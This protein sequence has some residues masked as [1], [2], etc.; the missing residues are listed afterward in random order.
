MRHLGDYAASTVIY[1]K[2][3][4]FR[5]STGAA[6]TLGGTPA[7]SV[8]KDNSTTQSTTGVTLTADFDAVTGLNHFA[9]DT[10]ADGAFYTAGS[11]FD[12]VITTGTVDSVS[13]V[14]TVV[15]SFSLAKTAALRPTTAGRT[16]DVTA[17]GEAG[18]DWSNIGGATTTVNLSGTTIKTATDVETDT[19][20]IQTKI[21]T[22]AG[23]SVSADIAAV[24]ADTAAI[25]IDTAEIG[26]AGAGLTAL[27]SA[28]N[29]A[30]VA[31][32][33]DTEVGTIVTAV[34]NI[35][36]DTQDIQARL[37]AALV[38]GRIDAS[39]GAMSANTLTASALA[40]DAVEE[41]ADGVW[42][43]SIAAHQA[44]NSAGRALTIS[45]TPLSE[46]TA[47][48]TPTTTTV[49]LTAGSAVDDFYNDLMILPVSG[50]LAGQARVITDYAGATRTITVD[51]AFTSAP[52]AGDAMVIIPRHSHS[53][54][55]LR[56]S[57]LSDGTPFAGASIAAIKSKTDNLAF[58]VSGQVDANAKSMNDATI[59]GNGTSGNL[60]RG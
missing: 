7:L 47:A 28:A 27:A 17:T 56:S 45:G 51:E 32:Y 24:K 44:V 54:N 9:I 38:G 25:L 26:A 55:Q 12:I 16:L 42:D 13:V 59:Q 11:N 43:E 1:G 39:V 40:T 49:Q 34:G 4:T 6:Y 21:G 3:T 15:A 19:A 46:T 10:S 2:F 14:G 29:L 48:G 58:T 57:I 31:G 18:I 20:D 60:W 52:A 50:A 36:A 23:A 53:L 41:I 35:E 22:P 37:P 33:I 5:P 30:T 8:Y